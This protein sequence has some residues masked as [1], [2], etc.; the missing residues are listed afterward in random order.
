MRFKVKAALFFFLAFSNT[1]EAQS[2]SSIDSLEFMHSP[3]KA[4]LRSAI[5]P[6]LGQAYNNKYW[7]IPV[8]YAGAAT[9]GYFIYFNNNQYQRYKEAY[10]YRLDN[11]P[12]TIDEFEQLGLQPEDIKAQKDYWRRNRDLC[13]IGMGALY[14]L[15]IIDAYVDAHLFYFN[16]AEKISMQVT[17]YAGF[18]QVAYTGINLN[19]KF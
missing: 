5:L 3:S 13:I 19:F 8:I 18:N 7:K 11:D 14:T 4:A 17:P 15:N 10:I 2:V 1:S 6:G 16:V 9:L 12:S